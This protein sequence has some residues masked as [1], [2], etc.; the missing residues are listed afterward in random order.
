MT[1]KQNS[2]G[3]LTLIALLKDRG[4]VIVSEDAATEFCARYMEKL[5]S[6]V[7]RNLASRF[8]SR[9]DPEDL[10]QSIFRSWFTGAEKGRFRP[11]SKDEVWKLLS[12]VAL[13][14]VRN[15]VK[16]HD[17]RKRAVSK[18]QANEE[19]LAS[20]PEPRP[21]D[22]TDF[23][24]LI[25]VAGQRLDE[26]ARRTLELILE[27]KSVEDIATTLGR[28]TKSVSRYKKQIGIVLQG[29]LDDDLK[30]LGDSSGDDGDE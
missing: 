26:M 1:D 27:G 9:F 13:N 23:L 19:L 10:V 20:V 6:L 3:D 4:N 8:S 14:K 17:A 24:E 18:T 11:S 21:E 25:D 5:M 7:E 16:F 15:K 2:I 28:T 12:V 29:L 22:A 30:G